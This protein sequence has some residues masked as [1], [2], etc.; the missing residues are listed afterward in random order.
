MKISKRSLS[1]LINDYLKESRDDDLS[2]FDKA[3][4]SHIDRYG[5]PP[6]KKAQAYRESN[7]TVYADMSLPTTEKNKSDYPSL[8]DF[9]EEYISLA[10]LVR[11]NV[12]NINAI[13][14]KMAQD[15]YDIKRILKK[16][17]MKQ[18]SIF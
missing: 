17:G 13:Y 1:F 10:S 7:P 9:Y 15:K 16:L 3:A 8:E 12:R 14:P 2:D 6:S 5:E 4:A 11:Q 18:D